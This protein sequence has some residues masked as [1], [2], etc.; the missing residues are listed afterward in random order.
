[1]L[2]RRRRSECCLGRKNRNKPPRRVRDLLLLALTVR[3]LSLCSPSSLTLKPKPL[4]ANSLPLPLSFSV[5][6]FFQRFRLRL[7]S[8]SPSHSDISLK[9]G[10]N[11]FEALLSPSSLPSWHFLFTPPAPPPAP[12]HRRGGRGCLQFI[13]LYLPPSSSLFSRFV[14]DPET[15]NRSVRSRLHFWGKVFASPAAS[16]SPPLFSAGSLHACTLCKCSL[17]S[18]GRGKA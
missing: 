5:R 4:I 14:S 15:D 18:A 1:M 11:V 9:G 2:R 17:R 7:H 12:P 10:T 6:I 16:V 3:C 8:S 13:S